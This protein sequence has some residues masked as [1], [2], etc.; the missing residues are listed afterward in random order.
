MQSFLANK[1]G[2]KKVVMMK[3]CLCLVACMSLSACLITTVEG[4]GGDP[5]PSPIGLGKV[6][7]C[8]S[9]CQ[10]NV[11][12]EICFQQAEDRALW[13]AET[14]N[15]MCITS[16]GSYVLQPCIIK[17]PKPLASGCNAT[18]GCY[19]PHRENFW[20]VSVLDDELE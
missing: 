3:F 18:F 7:I 20:D 15:S 8:A 4:D 9:T 10:P 12:M 1:L 19:C 6:Y 11:L 5:P 13:V 14:T 17:C 2:D 16:C